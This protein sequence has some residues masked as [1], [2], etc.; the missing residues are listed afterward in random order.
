MLK[1]SLVIKLVL[2]SKKEVFM[3]RR[4]DIDDE[5]IGIRAFQ[6]RKER[7]VERAIERIRH[8]LDKDWSKLTE[9]EIETLEWSLGEAWAMM[10]FADWERIGFSFMDLK[11]AKD[12][13]NIGTQVLAHKKM[14]TQAFEEIHKILTSLA[15]KEE[16]AEAT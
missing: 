12:I 14:G 13:I 15:P 4:Y 2:Q 16:E 11:T 9:P 5:D 6:L 8:G 1:Y 3:S 7:A 10:S